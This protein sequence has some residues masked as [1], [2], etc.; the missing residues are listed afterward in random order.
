[1]LLALPPLEDSLRLQFRSHRCG[2]WV[3]C[4]SRNQDRCCNL[5]SSLQ[6]HAAVSSAGPPR[7]I[8]LEDLKSRVSS[9]QKRSHLGGHFEN[10]MVRI[11]H[12]LPVFAKCVV[13]V[14]AKWPIQARRPY[15]DMLYTLQKPCQIGLPISGVGL[16]NWHKVPQKTAKT[17]GSIEMEGFKELFRD[18]S[19]KLGWSTNQWIHSLTESQHLPT[20]PLHPAQAIALSAALTAAMSSPRG[21]PASPSCQGQ[22]WVRGGRVLESSCSRCLEWYSSWKHLVVVVLGEPCLSVISMNLSIR[23]KLSRP[24]Q[25]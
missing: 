21:L 1:M 23:Y 15:A 6:L 13:D 2:V 25:C 8:Q 7:Q 19:R 14:V 11:N 16:L 3:L 10:L 4:A 12:M 5:A 18:G 24:V 20:H 9:S 22:P 17:P